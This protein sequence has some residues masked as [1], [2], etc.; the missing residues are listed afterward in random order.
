M[1]SSSSTADLLVPGLLLT[2]LSTLLLL[3]V[4]RDQAPCL[5]LLDNPG[6][7][8]QHAAPTP[9]VGG[10]AMAGALLLIWLLVPSARP[11]AW[12]AVGFA[13]LL[14]LGAVDDRKEISAS[15][16]FLIETFVV[17]LV[18]VGTGLALH[19]VGEI[20][21][22]VN[23]T[24]GW[25]A[26]PVAVFG[27]L[28][29]VNAVNMIDGVDGLAGS[30]LLVSFGALSLAMW[31]VG[32]VR[33]PMALMPCAALVGFLML[34]LRLPGGR[35]ARV[36]MGDGG[37]LALGYLL[38]VI[39]IMATQGVGKVP[40][41]VAVW[42]CALPLLDGV[43]VIQLRARRG[44]GLTT[45]GTDHFHHLLKAMGASPFGVTA[46]E[47]VIA[48]ALAA[49]GLGLWHLGVPDWISFL[50]FAV[51]AIGVRIFTDQAWTRIERDK[52]NR[53]MLAPSVGL[54]EQTGQSSQG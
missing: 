10:I 11:P 15:S 50:S 29:V 48:A 25:L 36:F 51:L 31:M 39:A 41:M 19:S 5:R 38:A 6:G 28:S 33:Y 45:P 44:T 27:V 24:L 13:A 49:W 12:V 3:M 46:T 14:A 23:G 17:L 35:P 7:R 40:P 21:P 26:I 54:D 47:A 34:N 9:L 42:A 30:V 8:K 4:L 16:K 20:L 22:G 1:I 43:T 37:T 2:V 32:D 18:C 53:A 52:A